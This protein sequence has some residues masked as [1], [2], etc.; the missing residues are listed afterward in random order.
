MR[1]IKKYLNAVAI[2]IAIGSLISV[3]FYSVHGPLAFKFINPFTVFLSPRPYTALHSL[4]VYSLIGVFLEST[5]W[6]FD[7]E[8]YKNKVKS[9]IHFLCSF[10]LFY[11]SNLLS[12]L[13]LGAGGNIHDFQWY[14]N[15]I[16]K[17][18]AFL[19]FI[20]PIVLIAIGYAVCWIGVWFK[21]NQ[22]ISEMNKK[23]NE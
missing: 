9:T 6:L 16:E 21:Y 13:P 17:H 20:L 8:S 23:I 2:S 19:S 1:T 12:V 10:L 5:I 11:L 4:I 15:S 7:T 3:L 18:Q 22:E 14:Y